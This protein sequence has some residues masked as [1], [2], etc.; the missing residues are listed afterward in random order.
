MYK[1]ILNTNKAIL[2][3]IARWYANRIVGKRIPLITL[4][5]LTN[6]CNFRCDFCRIWKDKDKSS[7]ALPDF[8]RVINSIAPYCLD[9]IVA[10]GEPFTVPDF[11]EYIKYA[12]EKVHCLTVVTNGSLLNEKMAKRIAQYPPNV[13]TVSIDKIGQEHDRQRHHKDAYKKA[14]EALLLAHRYFPKTS[15][16][17][18]AIISPDST[19][20]CR[21]LLKLAKKLNVDIFF[22]ALNEPIDTTGKKWHT[23]KWIF[24]KQKI[25]EL[26]DFIFEAVKAKNLT[27]SADYL[28]SLP[29]YFLNDLN[30]GVRIEKKCSIPTFMV[31]VNHKTELFPCAF[32]SAWKNGISVR[33]K[34]IVEVMNSKL[35]SERAEKLR[36]KC[37]FCRNHIWACHFEPRIAFPYTNTVKYFFFDKLV[38]K[39]KLSKLKRQLSA[40]SKL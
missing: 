15:R 11:P 17:I 39:F 2:K 1:L 26:I 25:L 37:R 5:H 6:Q 28:F 3:K 24:P 4:M 7:I 35:F 19:Q 34:N 8:K 22:Q 32:G 16:C 29:F 27:N 10:G 33:K 38:L 40:G 21:E 30:R 23:E 9:L 36:S 31:E 20:D 13:L 12:R 18:S 14:V